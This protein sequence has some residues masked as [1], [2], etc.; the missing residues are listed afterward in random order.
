MFYD[1]WQDDIAH[2][3]ASPPSPFIPNTIISELEEA[4]PSPIMADEEFHDAPEYAPKR[5][6]EPPSPPSRKRKRP[7]FLALKD[8]TIVTLKVGPDAQPLSIHRE[9][10][11]QSSK[12]FTKAFKGGFKEAEEN[13][14]AFKDV[15]VLTAQRFMHWLYTNTLEDEEGDETGEVALSP[16]DL[17]HLYVFGDRYDVPELRNQ[18]MRELEFCKPDG[19]DINAAVIIYAY[20]NLPDDSH[21]CRWLVRWY[22][23]YW[24]P[25]GTTSAQPDLLED[26]LPPAFVLSV[27]IMCRKRFQNLSSK[28][29]YRPRY[30]GQYGNAYCEHHDHGDNADAKKA[31][32]EEC[33]RLHERR[34]ARDKAEASRKQSEGDKAKKKASKASNT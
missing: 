33:N 23:H 25:N 27:A 29:S 4:I 8:Q 31:C 18:I 26:D 6:L 28:H 13:C 3:S 15:E 22:A 2:G 30:G 17:T 19:N 16:L 7:S 14:I 20:D 1:G 10:I 21:L 5:A 12:Y 24:D 11:C 34:V 9:M 32:R